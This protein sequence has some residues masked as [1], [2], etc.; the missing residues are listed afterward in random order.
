[1]ILD[2]E[3]YINHEGS[4]HLEMKTFDIDIFDGGLNTTSKGKVI[5]FVKVFIEGMY[6]KLLNTILFSSKTPPHHH[7][8]TLTYTH[9]HQIS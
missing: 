5:D 8:L 4:H 1:M 3:M 6:R 7:S 9:P 2:G